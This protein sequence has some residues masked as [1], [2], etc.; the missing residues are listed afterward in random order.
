MG[1][2]H[3][4]PEQQLMHTPRVHFAVFGILLVDQAVLLFHQLIKNMALLSGS[5][6]EQ[7]LAIEECE[8]SKGVVYV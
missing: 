6:T 8:Y 5:E 2:L 4:Q 7:D 1:R 3:S